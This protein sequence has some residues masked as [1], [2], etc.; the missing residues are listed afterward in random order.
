MHQVDTKS[1]ALI[2][3]VN[4]IGDVGKRVEKVCTAA[5]TLETSFERYLS[6]NPNL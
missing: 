4:H 1:A 2:D 6:I 5:A 3:H